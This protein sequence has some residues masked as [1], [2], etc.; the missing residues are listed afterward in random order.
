MAGGVNKV[1]L[2]GNL[3]ADPELRYTPG[4]ASVCE[5]RLATNESWTD[6]SGEKQERTEWHRIIVWGKRAEICSKYLSKGRQC[7]IEGR[8]RTRSWDDKDGNKR[9]TTEIVATDVQFLGGRGGNRNDEQVPLA[10]PD[11]SDRV[12][13]A[14]EHK[15]ADSRLDAIKEA[16]ERF[17]CA[18]EDDIPL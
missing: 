14:G 12:P 2:V 17:G 1:I 5:M 15:K 3:G 16:A 4:G 9:W 6:K 7:Y 11:G 8:L 13:G 18:G 10:E